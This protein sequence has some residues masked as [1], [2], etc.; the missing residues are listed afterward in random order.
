MHNEELGAGGIR[1]HGSC[2]GEHPFGMLQ[3]VLHAVLSKFSLDAVA[4][5]AHAGAFRTA[6][7][8]HKALDN[9]M[10]NQAVIKFLMDKT[11]KIV[12]GNGCCLRIKLQTDDISA[13]HC[14]G[15]NRIL[16]HAVKFPFLMI[17]CY[18]IISCLYELIFLFYIRNDR[19]TRLFFSDS[20]SVTA[21]GCIPFISVEEGN[22]RGKRQIFL[23]TIAPEEGICDILNM[24][25]RRNSESR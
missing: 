8:N 24:E 19:K 17:V 7:L 4:G 15:D 6:A 23:I 2:H 9:P 13:F 22:A 5:A 21:S 1:I 3:R 14:N 16:C 25:E 11:D 12:D 20:F 10:E 18:V